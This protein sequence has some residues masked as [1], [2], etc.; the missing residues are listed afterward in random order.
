MR[1]AYLAAA[2]AVGN[3]DPNPAVGAV[4][5]SDGGAILSRGYTHRAGFD[6]A[7]RHALAQIPAADLSAATM[8]V[9]L[10]PCC[11]HGRTP[12][13]V[14][15]ILERKIRR[16][17]I[18]ERDLAAEVMGRSV[19][20]LTENGVDVTLSEPGTF[21]NE[22]W[23]TTGPFFFSRKN[24][25]PRVTLKWAQTSDGAL[26]PGSGPSGPISGNVAAFVTAGLRSLN[27][28]TMATP[29]TVKTDQP[30]LTARFGEIPELAN[31][32]FSAFFRQLLLAQH[33]WATGKHTADDL[34]T[35]IKPAAQEFLSSS[36]EFHRDFGGTMLAKLGEIMRR[37][38]N[39]VLIEAGPVFS[40]LLLA[41]GLV[42]AIAVYRSKVKTAAMLW[43]NAGRGNSLSSLLAAGDDPPGF[44]AMERADLTHDDFF[45]FRRNT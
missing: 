27:K 20:I 36:G 37:G 31:S 32:G 29:G 14:D 44:T 10:E 22:A 24:L 11:H 35:A 2:N 13:C 6:H 21:T 34:R 25:R 38:F 30:K 42:D 8:Y 33:A 45:F 3:S 43:G 12:P 9:T 39:S 15:V 5:V 4:V 41:H 7:E 17:V 19:A 26:A 18:A 28:L 1:E 16:V 23:L 40:E